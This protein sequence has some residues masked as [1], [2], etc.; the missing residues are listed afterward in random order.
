MSLFDA[1]LGPDSIF[2][3]VSHG[4]YDFTQNQYLAFLRILGYE[5]DT[6]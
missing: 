2:I 4:V 5:N 3:F 1:M 6:K